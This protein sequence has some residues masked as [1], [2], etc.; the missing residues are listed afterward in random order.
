MSGWAGIVD[1]MTMRLKETV[2]VVTGASRGA[3][4]GIAR[5]LGEQGATVY[6]TGRSTRKDGSPTG[7]PETIE[8][9]ADEVTARGGTGI[10]VRVDHTDPAQVEAFFA[11]VE[12]E[13]G[14][15]DLLVSN[16][17][18][19]YERSPEVQ[20]FWELDLDHFD[21]MV[22]AGY[23][24]HLITIQHAA[25]LL[26][27]TR[28]GLAIFTTWAVGDHYH[29]NLYYDTVKTAINRIPL[30]VN[31]DLREYGV[32]ALALSPGWMRLERMNLREDDLPKTESP[33]FVGRAVAALAA[34]PEVARHGGGIMTVIEAAAEYGFT[35][36][37]GRTT[38][39]FWDKWLATHTFP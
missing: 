17:W 8:D 29:G 13:R 1:G 23:R 5:V 24:A 7:R 31:S 15:L 36:I 11:R 19:G 26:R 2:A 16:A 10:P 4:R 38:T 9:A 39:G 22:A 37:D 18:G 35:D 32:T 33:E 30:G 34:D 12:R 21:L 25:P 6:V 14:R 20:P 27:A 3:G 28:N